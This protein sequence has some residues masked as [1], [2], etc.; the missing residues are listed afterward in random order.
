MVMRRTE[1]HTDAA[2]IQT[3]PI[4]LLWRHRPAMRKK[5]V[6]VDGA[7]NMPTAEILPSNEA[8]IHLVDDMAI[9][10]PLLLSRYEKLLSS[11]E[12]ERR[13]RFRFEEHRHQF[14]VARA[15]LRSTLS[16]YL[17]E[18]V[19]EAWQFEVNAYGR[20]RL[21]QIHASPIDF[22]LSHT[23]GRIVLAV[24]RCLSPGVDIERLDR[25][26][27]L[28]SLAPSVFTPQELGALQALPEHLQSQRFFTLWT[29]KE[30]YIKAKGKGLSIPLQEFGFH[31]DDEPAPRICFR[32]ITADEPHRWQFLSSV[33]DR[34]YA[35][36]LAV[37]ET[38]A[39]SIRW[40]RTVPLICAEEIADCD[41][42]SVPISA[43]AR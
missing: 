19:P 39:L 16:H 28:A 5:P 18:V 41:V 14:L 7:T 40:F 11:A 20:P 35:F 29:L 3:V 6:A 37:E 8:H 43:T 2:C 10:D 31:L 25:G 30:A 38:A 9:N 15:L 32:Q 1:P 26:G 36:A 12:Q 22:N 27:E 42:L 4:S 24:T 13:S 23:R 17:P 21:A 34:H 33:V